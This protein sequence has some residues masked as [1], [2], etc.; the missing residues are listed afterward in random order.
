MSRGSGFL[1]L[2]LFC[3][4]WFVTVVGVVWLLAGD[5]V[6]SFLFFCLR[7]FLLRPM[8]CVL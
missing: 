7:L 6:G 4:G 1:G 5:S 2:G 3:R 8:F